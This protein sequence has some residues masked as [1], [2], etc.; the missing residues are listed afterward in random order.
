MLYTGSERF[1]NLHSRNKPEGFYSPE[2]RS[3][4]TSMLALDPT[5]RLSVAEI[6]AHPWYNGPVATEEE[7][8][9]E[10]SGRKAQMEGAAERARQAKEARL[11]AAPGRFGV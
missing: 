10:M 5:Q 7:I 4:L 1:W 2:F 6:K 11:N 9:A 8:Q 3:L